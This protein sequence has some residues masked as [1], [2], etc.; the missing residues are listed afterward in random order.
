MEIRTV[1]DLFYRSVDDHRKPDL[2]R[3]KRGGAWCD[4]GS[5]DLR[6]AVEETSM[7]LRGLGLQPGASLAI[8]SEN[9]PEW[10]FADQGAQAAGAVVVPVYATLPAEQVRYIL[11]DSRT[12]VAVVSTAAQ[13]RKLAAVRPRLPHLRQVVHLNEDAAD[14]GSLS[15]EELRR[16]GAAALAGDQGAVRERASR[17]TPD[18]LATV[19]YTSGTTGEPKGAMLTHGNLASNA[20]ASVRHFAEVLGPSATALSFLPLCHAFERTAGYHVMMV[21]GVT[22]AYAESIEQVAANMLEVRPTLMCAVPRLYEKMYARV[23][24]KVAGDPEPRQRVFHWAVGVGREVFR[25]RNEGR[26]PGFW[27]SRQHALADRLVLGKIRERTGGRMRLFIS[28]GAPLSREIAEFFG[29]AG[30]PI[31][32]GYGL[33]ESSPVIT[34]N[35]PHALRPGTVG[36]ALDGVEVKL[37]EDGEVLTRGPHVMRGYLGRPQDTAAAVDAEGWL[38]T[39]DVGVLSADHFLTITDRKKDIIVTSGGKNLA[40]QPIENA[41]KAHPLVAEVVMIGNARKYPAALI[42]PDFAALERWAG[43]AGVAFAGRDDLLARAEVVSEYE[44][45]VRE[46]SQGLAQH[47]RIRRISLLPRELTVEAGELTPTLK[48]RRRVVEER[49]RAVID[50][51]YAGAV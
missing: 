46:Q 9:R 25:L 38:H 42:V 13:A 26:R 22:I 30:L 28:G 24:E 51:M 50:R 47:E 35:R 18:D 16:R 6:R 40:P 27:L 20:V 43:E 33:T 31:A 19:I 14:E 48:V 12:V 36:E 49:Y 11:D 15:L 44:R 29:A 2:L 41:L 32:E 17:V 37:A 1:C 39:G 21:T 10:V 7:G 23:R 3:H 5:D 4:I 34:A 8:L 45:I